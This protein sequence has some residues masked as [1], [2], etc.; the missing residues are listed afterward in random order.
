MGNIVGWWIYTTQLLVSIQRIFVCFSQPIQF[1]RQR[2]VPFLCLDNFVV[3]FV[4][5]EWNLIIFSGVFIISRYL[6]FHPYWNVFVGVFVLYKQNFHDKCREGNVSPYLIFSASA[7]TS[8]WKKIIFLY[9]DYSIE[10]KIT[11]TKYVILY[12]KQIFKII[13]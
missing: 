4:I 11:Y 1:R 6:T 8:N 2:I 9:C 7:S 10:M 12:N 5:H 13:E 3:D